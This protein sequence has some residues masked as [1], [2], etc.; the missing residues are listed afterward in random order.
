ML[1]NVNNENVRKT[2]EGFHTFPKINEDGVVKIVMLNNYGEIKTPWFGENFQE[3][4]YKENRQEEIEIE[5]SEF[6][7]SQVGSGS[8]VIQLEVDTREEE[9]WQ[10][11]VVVK[12]AG[13]G[14]NTYKLYTDEDFSMKTWS[15]AEAHCQAEGGHLASVVLDKSQLEVAAAAEAGGWVWLGGTDQ[16]EEG[17][18][19]WS[20]GSTWNYTRWSPESSDG[21]PE[22][23]S[24]GASHNCAV[25]HYGEW[26]R[27]HP[28][29]F[30][31]NF[32]CQ[33]AAQRIQGK[34][35][36]TLRFTNK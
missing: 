1:A 30:S 3:E 13:W 9:G 15:G 35:N 2:Y 22:Y 20:D 19:R 25:I 27:N 24:K 21:T 33:S 31:Q 14:Y 11:E 26:W 4:F 18:W 7:K 10:E 36:I 5:I 29:S 32:L 6:L 12:K 28:C 16:E 17:V 23:G 34:K 8:L